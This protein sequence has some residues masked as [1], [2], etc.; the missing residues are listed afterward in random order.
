[1]LTDPGIMKSW[2]GKDGNPGRPS[3]K[4]AREIDA[5]GILNLALAGDARAR[6]IVRLRADIVS[7]II[8]NVSLILN[9]RPDPSWWRD[10]KSSFADPFHP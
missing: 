5:V 4:H 8:V 10:R 2:K 9:P 6:T 7:D 3:R 1:V